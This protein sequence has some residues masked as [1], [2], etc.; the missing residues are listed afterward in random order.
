VR[1]WPLGL[2]LI[3][4]SEVLSLTVGT[5]QILFAYSRAPGR[6]PFQGIE[7]AYV[8]VALALSLGAV[9]TGFLGRRKIFARF[10]LIDA[11]LNGLGG[12]WF[13]YDFAEDAL[14]DLI[15]G[16]F[17]ISSYLKV[18]AWYMVWNS[19]ILALNVVIAYYLCRYELFGSRAS[20][21][22]G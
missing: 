7:A 15:K 22:P 8:I 21:P 16:Q 13:N 11:V 4:W 2:R 6:F 10:G 9:V 1:T 17:S 12:I 14:Q 20:A 18:G 19:A 5:G 3:F